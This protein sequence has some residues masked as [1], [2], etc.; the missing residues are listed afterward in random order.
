MKQIAT[1]YSISGSSVTMTGVNVPLS[2]ILLVSNATT[3]AVLYS[4]AGPA[5]S[6][7]TQAVNSVIGLATTPS[8][9]DRLTI[10]FDDG[11]AVS[12]GP[13]SVSVSNFP[14]TQPVS[15]TVGVS[16]TVPVS[17]PLTDTQL[18]ATAVPVSGTVTANTGLT[19]PLT[20]TQLRAT[21]VPISVATVPSHPVTNAGTFAVQNTAATPAG[22]N[23]IGTVGLNAGTN[24][25]GSITN[26]SFGV[27]SLPSLPTGSNVIGGVTLSSVSGSATVTNLAAPI[28]DTTGYGTFA[29]QIPGSILTGNLLVQG[30]IDGTTFSFVNYTSLPSGAQ[31]ITLSAATATLGIIDVS[32]FKAIRFMPQLGFTGPLTIP[33]NLSGNSTSFSSVPLPA[34]SN[35]IGSVNIPRASTA[36]RSDFTVNADALIVAAST[37]RQMLAIYNVGPSIL[38]IGLGA[39]AVSS[40]NFSYFLNAGDTYVAEPNEVGLMHRGRFETLGNVAEVT[41]GF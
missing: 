7:Y 37:S 1:A 14:A 8:A 15:G 2:Q 25:I 33:Y 9:T 11:V 18:R 31:S 13:T 38:R 19:Q 36:T 6:S 5:A 40:T 4:M 21:A 34:G 23:S 28:I 3:G 39:T 16:G 22:S 32:G 30:S 12:N 10:F 17:G 27:S 24:A 35:T 20:D 26:T 41:E 29:F